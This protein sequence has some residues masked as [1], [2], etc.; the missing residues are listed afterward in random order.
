[1]TEEQLVQ[2]VFPASS[3][4][5][6]PLP[7]SDAHKA[8]PELQAASEIGIIC[9]KPTPRPA[10]PRQAF[11][12]IPVKSQ[13]EVLRKKSFAQKPGI[14]RQELRHL[15]AEAGRPLRTPLP[16]QGEGIAVFPQQGAAMTSKTKQKEQSMT[17]KT[18]Q[19]EVC[20]SCLDVACDMG[21][22]TSASRTCIMQEFSPELPGH[23]CD[24]AI[25]LGRGDPDFRHRSCGGRS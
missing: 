16:L 8:L 2:I 24:A 10:V 25:G 20:D 21:I 7:V 13:H 18:K 14:D 6:S 3:K 15:T 9:G 22:G 11:L 17:S 5:N 4:K 23:P 12:P 19:I 1:M